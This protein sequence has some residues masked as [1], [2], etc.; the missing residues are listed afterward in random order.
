M[1][2]FP[3]NTDAPIYHRPIGTVGLIVLCILVFLGTD[4]DLLERYSLPLGAGLTPLQWLTSNFLHG[5]ALHLVGNMFF[6]W[7]FGLVVEGKLGWQRFVPLFLALGICECA[8][9]QLL[10][11]NSSGISFGASSAIFG[12]MAI[13]LV[14]APLNE[15]TIVGWIVLRTFVHEISIVWFASLLLGKSLLVCSFTGVTASSEFLHLLGAIF[16]LIAGFAFLKLRWVDCE[17]WDLISVIQGKHRRSSLPLTHEPLVQRKVSTRKKR[18]RSERAPTPPGPPSATRFNTLLAQN[19]P[20][21]A[22]QEYSGLRQFKPDW[23]PSAEQLL[24]L[25]RGLRQKREWTSALNAYRDYLALCPKPEPA[26]RLEV[27][28][29]LLFIRDRPQ[30]ALKLIK[31]VQRQYLSDRD[32]HRYDELLQR[33]DAMVESGVLELRDESWE[34]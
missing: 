24:E 1:F 5:S 26:T 33:A 32:A 29:I 27:A 10:L 12:L 16:G 23:A 18:T 11:W 7:G 30:A 21:A 17:D 2:I 20:L 14:W 34:L 4:A 31:A 6:L 19:K 28:E 22:W 8:L 3:V 13:A 9:E 25:A 15:L